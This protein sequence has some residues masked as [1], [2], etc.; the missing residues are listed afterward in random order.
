MKSDDA[1]SV[2]GCG[3]VA[4]LLFSMLF[5][6]SVKTL[7]NTLLLVFGQSVPVEVTRT[8][9]SP[10]NNAQTEYSLWYKGQVGTVSFNGHKKVDKSEFD[11]Y[12]QGEQAYA[13]I[14]PSNP[15]AHCLGGRLAAAEKLFHSLGGVAKA[16]FGILFFAFLTALFTVLWF[17]LPARARARVRARRK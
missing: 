6:A 13:L 8:T 9:S 1:R 2:F 4:L 14:R 7:D 16:V 15:R 12:G 5:I 17:L 10:Q 3:C 11:S